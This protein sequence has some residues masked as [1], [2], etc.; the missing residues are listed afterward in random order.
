[1]RAWITADRTRPASMKS[2]C[3]ISSHPR[4]AIVKVT[5]S[6]ICGVR[7]SP[8][9]GLVP[10]TRIGQTFGHE[11]TGIVEQVGPECRTSRSETMSC[12]VHIACGQCHFCKQALFGNCHE[13]NPSAD[14]CRRH[15]RLSHTA[16]G[17][18]GGQAQYARVPMQTPVR[19]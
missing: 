6:C 13:S 14:R 2:R 11:F 1:M 5:R 18:D 8:D 12:P 15:L 4:D 16:G 7:P 9:H 17:F 10:D 19:R 3:P